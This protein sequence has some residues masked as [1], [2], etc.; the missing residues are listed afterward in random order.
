MTGQRVGSYEIVRVLARGGMAVVYLAY[1]PALDREVALK[2]LDLDIQDV[3]IAQRFVRE[4]RMA[5]GLDHPNVVTLFDFFEHDGVPYI[6][7]EYVSGGSL[8]PLV[9]DLRLPQVFGVLEGVLNGLGH[10]EERSIAHRDLK[11]ENVLI[12]GRGGVKIADFGIARAYDALTGHLTSTSAAIGTPAYMAPEQALSERL[13]PFTDLYAVGIMA[14]EML[15]G[16][17]PFGNGITPM[18]VLYAHVH[19]PPPPL[20]DRAPEAPASLR[21]W[22]EWLLAKTPE[23]RPASAAEAWEALE[24]IAVAE[25]GP[26]WRRSAAVV[27]A[28]E[29]VTT[30]MTTEEPTTPLPSTQSIAPEPKRSRRP[31]RLAVLVGGLSALGA[32]AVAAFVLPESGRAP[33][34]ERVAVAVP[35]DFDGDGRQELVVGMPGSAER[36][37]DP[38]GG[39]VVVHRG[40]RRDK[41]MVITP[42][43]AGL[44][45]PYLAGDDFGWSPQS[46]DFDR[47]GWADLAI[48]VPGR[49]LVAILYGSDDGLLNGRREPI[50]DRG[51]G[52]GTGRYG[53]RVA[54]GDFNGDGFADL[55]VGV[56]FEDEDNVGSVGAVNV[57]YGSDNG[58]SSAGDQYLTE[59]LFGY[60][61]TFDDRF[62]AALASG[63][64][65]GDGFA[66]LAIGMPGRAPFLGDPNENF[67]AVLLIDGSAA[68]L[69]GSTARTL[70][71]LDGVGGAAGGGLAWG[72]FNHDGFGDLAV[73]IPEA[74]G[75]LSVDAG[76]VQVFFGSAEGLT[77]S[78]AQRFR[79]SG[80]SRYGS[81]LAAGD[82]NRDG[83]SD[84][85]IGVPFVDFGVFGHTADVGEVHLYRGT[86]TG[87]HLAQVIGQGGDS[88]DQGEAGDQFGFALAVGDFNG[89][90]RDDLAVGV[91]NEDL[92]GNTVADAGAV[93]IFFG[94][95]GADDLVDDAGDMFFGQGSLSGVAIEAG[96]R[97]GRALTAG[98][99]NGDPYADLAIGVPGEDIGTIANAGMVSVLYGSSGGPFLSNIQHW[100]ESLASLG[101]LEAES[102]DEFGRALSA[103]NYGRT[104]HADLAIGVP[105]EDLFSSNTNSQQVDAGAVVLIYGSASGL[106]A[107]G[108]QQWHQ[109]RAGIASAASAGD[110]FG[111]TLY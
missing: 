99:F 16:R 68:G 32:A 104:S 57:I 45:A 42:G 46:G 26:Y 31:R 5:A 67:G 17:P 82:F 34:P 98:K 3:T 33:P 40:H 43:D 87:L 2:Q 12:T 80:G 83:I 35:F 78:G 109:D 36:E 111:V 105:F 23:D 86:P 91:P 53:Q 52:S 63:D 60:P 75:F 24:E 13:G 51:L 49:D 25:L 55:A 71:L 84:L 30:A 10:A 62:G 58:L 38:A 65:N 11:P 108:A 44:N 9:G 14:Y 74:D 7:M 79:G 93:H 37:S 18:A 28:P 64:F 92:L 47:D 85:A 76:E 103:W 73:G 88:A 19:Q 96:D 66:D 70:T 61:Y 102:G 97:M 90:A 22:V 21:A 1:Q 20:A 41:P 94:R 50:G 72:D 110:R 4:A 107:T 69:V 54:A 106:T 29:Q 48:G 27:P 8:R 100:D 39:L 95:S 59:T 101:V 6:A 56:P 89:D 81:P 15:A 77:Q